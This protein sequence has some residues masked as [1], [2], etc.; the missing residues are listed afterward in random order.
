M[1]TTQLLQASWHPGNWGHQAS[2]RKL[3]LVFLHALDDA[4]ALWESKLEETPLPATYWHIREE[5]AKIQEAL[6][7][8]DATS[9]LC[10]MLF[11]FLPRVCTTPMRGAGEWTPRRDPVHSSLRSLMKPAPDTN[12]VAQQTDE[13]EQLYIG[14]DIHQ[15]LQ[16]VFKGE[17]D[18][19]MIARSLPPKSSATR[20]RRLIPS[21]KR[22][23]LNS[24]HELSIA[25]NS[26]HLQGESSASLRRNL[27]DDNVVPGEGWS[28]FNAPGGYCGESD[29]VHVSPPSSP[30]FS[31]SVH[32][33]SPSIAIK[34]WDSQ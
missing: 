29:Y 2:A 4:L 14:R 1:L 12:Y 25:L 15:P 21:T 3:S 30:P 28:V 34:R 16:R 27:A 31:F 8:E 11:D 24:H 26:S 33:S 7:N 32:H 22:R 6:K 17:V 13:K 10:G 9:T 5:E 19:A 18:V 23:R 20:R